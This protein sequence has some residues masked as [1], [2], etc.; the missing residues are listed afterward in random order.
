MEKDEPQ[1]GARSE[2]VNEI[3]GDDLLVSRAIV[4]LSEVHSF[5]AAARTLGVSVS[6]ITR[7]VQRHEQRLGV[8]LFLRSTHGLS[9][10]DSGQRYAEHLRRWLV[11]EEAIRSALNAERRAE[12]GSLRITV[13]VFVAERFLLDTLRTF[14]VAYP[15][16]VVEVHASDDIRDVIKEGFDLAI[17]LGPLANSN[18]RTRSVASFRRWTV[19]SPALFASRPA[20]TEP[21]E[22]S[23]FPCLLYLSVMQD[24]KWEFWARTGE[25]VLVPVTGAVRSNNLELLRELCIAGQGVARLPDAVVSPALT[26]GDLVQL[27]PEYTCAPFPMRPTLY[28]V[29]AKDPGKDRLREAFLTTLQKTAAA[30]F[31]ID[32]VQTRAG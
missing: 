12:S 2:P 4:R 16:V 32:D 13:P 19:A 3:S 1:T 6:A 10:T 23:S 11:E 21:A 28:A 14:R 29:H 20:P 15:Q 24:D 30:Q 26:R 5:S 8:A 18:L 9:P 31:T 22:L 7:A 27:F 25:S 17:R